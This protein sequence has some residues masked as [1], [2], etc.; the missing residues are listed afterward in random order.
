VL[1]IGE[2]PVVDSAGTKDRSRRCTVVSGDHQPPAQRS[3]LTAMH[4]SMYA[5]TA[6][7]LAPIGANVDGR[8]VPWTR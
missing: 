3:D 5:S 4:F 1:D 6:P 8:S 7:R 2:V